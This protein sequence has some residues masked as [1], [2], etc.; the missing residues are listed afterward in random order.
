MI[1]AR[2]LK[3]EEAS[4][5]GS[6]VED[7]RQNGVAPER[8][9]FIS[10]QPSLLA[11]LRA[12]EGRQLVK[13]YGDTVRPTLQAIHALGGAVRT[14]VEQGMTTL[15]PLLQSACRNRPEGPWTV[16]EIV[17]AAQGGLTSHSARLLLTL[18]RDIELCY[19][20]FADSVLDV[21]FQN[22]SVRIDDSVLDVTEK[23]IRT[24]IF[25]R[26]D[27]ICSEAE[28]LTTLDLVVTEVLGRTDDEQEVSSLPYR[29]G[30][31]GTRAAFLCCLKEKLLVEHNAKKVG[32]TQAGVVA[33]RTDIAL[34][35]LRGAHRLINELRGAFV[36][37]RFKV[38][39]QELQQ[40]IGDEQLSTRKIVMFIDDI[41]E[42]PYLWQSSNTGIELQLGILEFA[43]EK[44]AEL[45]QEAPQRVAGALKLAQHRSN[46]S[47]DGDGDGVEL[48]LP[49]SLAT[50]SEAKK[51]QKRNDR[52]K[53]VQLREPRRDDVFGNWKLVKHLG[54]GGQG[55]L[56]SAL[57]AEV[58]NS[59][60]RAIKLCFAEDEK[61]RER[62]RQELSHL[63]KIRHP[64]VAAFVDGDETFRTHSPALRA[65]A[66]V[67]MELADGDLSQPAHTWLSPLRALHYF[68]DAC[69]GI[70]HLHSLGIIHRDLKPE[71]LLVGGEKY[72]VVV[73]DLGIAS[74]A[75]SDL[76]LTET[77]E[78]VGSRFYRAP[79]VLNGG[80]ATEQS[81]IY[82]L[83]RILEFLFTH[84]LPKTQRPR[85]VAS[86]Q[87]SSSLAARLDSII[88]RATS[89]YVE[90]RY[91][92]V[93]DLLQALP[94][95][96]VDLRDQTSEREDVNE[97][98]S[99]TTGNSMAVVVE[100]ESR[101][102]TEEQGFAAALPSP[103]AATPAEPV[104]FVESWAVD[105]RTAAGRARIHAA[106]V[107]S[108]EETLVSLLETA[109][110]GG[111][112]PIEVAR[113]REALFIAIGARLFGRDLSIRRELLHELLAVT[114][115]GWRKTH[116]EAALPSPATRPGLESHNEDGLSFLAACWSWSLRCKR[117][118]MP[119]VPQG[120][121]VGWERWNWSSLP[122]WVL[123]LGCDGDVGRWLLGLAGELVPSIDGERDPL[124]LPPLFAANLISSIATVPGA[125]GQ[126][127]HHRWA[128]AWAAEVDLR[129]CWQVALR[130]VGVQQTVQWMRGAGVKGLPPDIDELVDELP[131]EKR[132]A[133]W[134]DELP[135]RLRFSIV[136]S[137]LRAADGAAIIDLEGLARTP[138]LPDDF[139]TQQLAPLLQESVSSTMPGV[140][141]S[142]AELLW[143][144]APARAKEMLGSAVEE[145]IRI[146]LL[147]SAPEGVLADA[148][149]ALRGVALSDPMRAML[150][151][152]QFVHP[153]LETLAF[154]LLNPPPRA[155][156]SVEDR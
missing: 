7:I 72:R 62:F 22:E 110:Q 135:L 111:A 115:P 73:A 93:E 129:S 3:A 99:D 124:R 6:L 55:I 76:H 147:Q 101:A 94:A 8:R 121:F 120:L 28:L 32:L 16:S 44:V 119:P 11:P 27:A 34:S 53:P 100:S 148:L 51:K 96:V 36:Q 137:A 123:R 90:D 19:A 131:P 91:P 138:S 20:V 38:S 64:H 46:V 5:I 66:F 67:V 112:D 149:V 45:P 143:S 106:L 85:S 117:D 18:F 50:S 52:P 152:I 83:G 70:A 9:S 107:A 17:A 30:A 75:D 23:H 84:Q 108:D 104:R 40:M 125:S 87:L 89:F 114:A 116:S 98:E 102:S 145:V 113:Q 139:V 97:H 48:V 13:V 59:P 33:S 74:S 127:L 146:R 136:R 26:P 58:K 43:P 65:C 109:V 151:R 14:E 12:L 78:I 77:N 150:R 133:P 25:E 68:R 81:D 31:R 156:A 142:A 41:S 49:G 4:V 122:D 60:P 29:T 47:S 144:L 21:R 128:L 92:R 42:K 105:C 88:E 153:S 95:V 82:S 56:W 54:G 1:D 134:N 61:S 15:L 10:R 63:R 2:T 80:D 69:A 118:E 86:D 37:N 130:D 126:I 39:H 71:N 140:G 35:L 132:Y 155:V 57:P 141:S 103:V 79:E 24:A 154:Q